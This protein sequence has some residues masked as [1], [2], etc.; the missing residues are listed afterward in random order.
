MVWI[1]NALWICCSIVLAGMVSFVGLDASSPTLLQS[2]LACVGSCRFRLRLLLVLWS[3]LILPSDSSVLVSR[4]Y[5]EFCVV[6]SFL[7]RIVYLI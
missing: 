2:G 5:G 3:W 7:L 6:A 4:E 1:V